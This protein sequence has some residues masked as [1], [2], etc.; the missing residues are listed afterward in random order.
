MPQIC[1]SRWTLPLLQPTLYD[2][3]LQCW[4]R[5]LT[6]DGPQNIPTLL[7][8]A[9]GWIPLSKTQVMQR[10]LLH[11]FC[12]TPLQNTLAQDCSAASNKTWK[13]LSSTTLFILKYSTCDAKG[14]PDAS[15]RICSPSKVAVI[16]CTAGW[17][18]NKE[19]E[20]GYTFGTHMG[21]QHL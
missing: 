1:W 10:V 16:R 2:N 15:K 5:P 8:M 4:I 19:Q 18:E 20:S 9:Y 17:D 11:L 3:L 14:H 7:H 13:V 12:R 21:K 6:D